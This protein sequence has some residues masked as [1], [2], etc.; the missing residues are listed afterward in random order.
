ML[1]VNTQAWINTHIGSEWSFDLSGEPV[2]AGVFDPS[3]H[4]AARTLLAYSGYPLL[5]GVDP[6]L[7]P[8]A[9]I[10]QMSNRSQ[11]NVLQ[12]LHAP[13]LL[14]STF[15]DEH[16]IPTLQTARFAMRPAYLIADPTAVNRSA[17]A[18]NSAYGMM[19]DK[20]FDVFVASTNDIDPRIRATERYFVEN[21]GHSYGEGRPDPAIIIDPDCCPVLIAALSGEYRYKRKKSGELEVTPEKKHPTSDVVDCLGYVA[22]GAGT[23]RVR[24]RLAV[25][26]RFGTS[27]GVQQP[28][29]VRGWT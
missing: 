29:P 5:V 11:L 20:G 18:A 1:L 15:L 8:A 24:R 6:G 3:Y 25:Q 28:P 22:L 27:T 21:R 9:L 14:F 12:E 19:E 16:L 26:G 23:S 4:V 10:C 17:L 13:N 7:H 2:Y